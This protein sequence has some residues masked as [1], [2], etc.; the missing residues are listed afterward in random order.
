M[1][2]TH[3]YRAV[4]TIAG[5]DSGGGAGI[6]ADLK[7]FSALGCFGASA[8]TAITAQ[9]TTGVSGIHPVPPEMVRAQ[10]AA[11]M[12]DIGP[13]AIKI[14]MIYSAAQ[15][16]AVRDA[17]SA[18][19][20]VPVVFDPVMLASTGEALMQSPT[21]LH[22]MEELFP[23]TSL[24]TPNLNETEVFC[25]FPIRHPD[26][27]GRAATVLLKTGAGAVLIKGGHLPGKRIRDLYLDQAGCESFFESDRIDSANLHGT[28]C[29]LSAAIAAGMAL[30][31]TRP[32]AIA[33]A[34]AYVL[35]AI[36]SGRHIRTGHGQ[37]PLNHFSAPQV[38]RQFPLDGGR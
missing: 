15:A 1:P 26:D 36:E 5:S 22:W 10:I 2:F 32:K 38:L 24:L 21:D 8:I 18:Y 12:E 7:T 17:L 33:H 23:L 28:G 27:M 34:R 13:R 29:T 35:Q 31:L 14:G 9:N 11:V 30:G 16:D 3:T 4:L 25:G 20:D 6:Q 19:P 37:G